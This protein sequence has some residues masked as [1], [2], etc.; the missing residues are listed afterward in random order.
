MAVGTDRPS[1]PSRALQPLRTS[2][3]VGARLT[4]AIPP[5]VRYP[6]AA[7]GG[8]LWWAADQ[9]RR[10]AA[11]ANYAAVLGL[12][13]D[14][15]RVR[16][17]ARRAFANYGCMLAD[18]MLMGSATPEELGRMV[19]IDGIEHVEAARARGRGVILVLP[20][21]GSWD[22][23][24]AMA[25]S[26]GY[27]VAAVTDAFPGSLNDVVVETR[28][29]YGMEVIPLNR[30]ALRSINAVLDGQGIVALLCDLPHGPGAEVRFFGRRAVV[31][32]GPA[33]IACRR[34]VPLV[35]VYSRRTDSRRYHIHVDP[36]IEPPAPDRC[37]GKEGTAEVMQRVI[38]RF[39]GFI[40]E[41]PDQWYA[42]RRILE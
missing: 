5:A 35:P 19:T 28:S 41:H 18:F 30:S 7:L 10:H 31:P 38:D 1:A 9:G 17:V 14:D 6:A 13:E 33:A 2:Y 12:P 42:F 29:M 34:Q 27:R 25:G 23:A 21:M 20:H 22:V 39:E 3:T 11:G 16:R 24:A 37:R 26:W 8:T 4:R 40:R 32:S 15:P 36:P